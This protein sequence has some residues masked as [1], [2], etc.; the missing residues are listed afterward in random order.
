[1]SGERAFDVTVVILTADRTSQ[2]RRLL[3]A[4][5]TYGLM[6]KNKKERHALTAL[7]PYDLRARG[8]D[9]KLHLHELGRA[10]RAFVQTV[11]EG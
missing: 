8:L 10:L 11:R 7:D 3:D 6:P 4:L 2:L 9:E 5:V 1:M